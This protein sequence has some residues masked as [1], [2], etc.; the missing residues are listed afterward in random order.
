[1]EQLAT[2]GQAKGQGGMMTITLPWVE[3]IRERL[4]DNVKYMNCEDM[5]YQDMEVVMDFIRP[6][7]EHGKN[8]EK[9]IDEEFGGE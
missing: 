9:R 8:E 4:C 6:I 1:M 3:R 5:K 2:Q 7:L